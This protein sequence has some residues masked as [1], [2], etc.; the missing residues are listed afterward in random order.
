MKIVEV[1]KEEINKFFKE[2]Q[3]HTHTHTHTHTHEE[4]KKEMNE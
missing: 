3:E 4:K 1:F 2:I